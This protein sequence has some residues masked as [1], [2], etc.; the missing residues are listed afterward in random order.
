MDMLLSLTRTDGEETIAVLRARSLDANMQPIV[1]Q[2]CQPEFF[3]RR[4]MF[5]SRCIPR[6]ST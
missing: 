1:R 5:K 3:E 6:H 2:K 4:R